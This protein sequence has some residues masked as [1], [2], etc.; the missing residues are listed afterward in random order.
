MKGTDPYLSAEVWSLFPE[1]L[2]DSQLGPIP[3]GWE[4][5]TLDDTVELLSGGTPRTSVASYWNGDIPW[6]TAKDAPSFGDVFVLDTERTITPVW[7]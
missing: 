3:D 1:Q 7:S 5:G 6:Y 4:I 2:V